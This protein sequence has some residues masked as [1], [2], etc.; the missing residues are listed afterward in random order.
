[1]T[2]LWTEKYRPQT[3]EDYVSK[4]E[5]LR[6][7]MEEW[8]R[9]GDIPHIGFFGPAGTGKTSAIKVLLNGLEANGHLDPSDV[10][11]LN[12]SDEGIDAVRDKIDA[13]AK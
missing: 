5:A 4:N 3:M 2:T 8:I 9:T 11:T 13:A 7:K 6:Q 1:M 12:M 10:T